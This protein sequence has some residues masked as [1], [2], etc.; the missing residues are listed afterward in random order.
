[1]WLWICKNVLSPDYSPC[2]PIAKLHLE[3]RDEIYSLQI[4]LSRTQA[5]PV[6]AVKEQQE[7]NSPNHVQR[8]NLIS[9]DTSK[10]STF[11]HSLYR[12]EI[13]SLQMLLSRTQAG[14]GRTVKQEQEETSQ[15]HVQRINLISVVSDLLNLDWWIAQSARAQIEISR[16]ELMGRWSIEW[17]DGK[18]RPT[19]RPTMQ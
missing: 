2:T 5:G 14:P 18:S 13:Y 1:M 16:V 8:I 11:S 10:S 12:D 15:N 17:S 3:Y 7:Q 4:L 6:R 19:L 9:V